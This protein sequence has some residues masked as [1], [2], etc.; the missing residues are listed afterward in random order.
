LLD[1]NSFERNCIIAWQLLWPN[2]EN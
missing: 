1:Q 2:S